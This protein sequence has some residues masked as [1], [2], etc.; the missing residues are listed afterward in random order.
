MASAT[1]HA[2]MGHRRNSLAD[3][4]AG[5]PRSGSQRTI[6]DGHLARLRQLDAVLRLAVAHA[7][8]M[9][10]DE[11]DGVFRGIFISESE[12]DGLID[13]GNRPTLASHG[14]VSVALQDF[15]AASAIEGISD[16]WGFSDFDNGVLVLALA[17]ELDLR[18]ERIY[19]Y[20]QDD[21]T[22]RRPTV[23]LALS[24]LCTDWNARLAQ[25]R[26]F[27]PDAPLLRSGMLR[28]TA[29][30]AAVDPPL[31]TQ[32]LRLDDRVVRALVG[33]DGLDNRLAAF[34]QRVTAPTGSLD[35][36]NQA[37]IVQRLVQYATAAA[38]GADRPLRLLFSGPATSGKR[39]AAAGLAAGLG[40]VLLIADLVRHPEWR[41][42]PVGTATL[43]L[44]EAVLSGAMLYLDG[45]GQSAAED[46]AATSLLR[47]LA[48]HPG[49]A[50]VATDIVTAPNFADDHRVLR[51]PFSLP[52]C[53]TQRLLWQRLAKR[54]G[55]T[56][57]SD[58]LDTLANT[59]QLAPDQIAEVVNIAHQR[60]DWR[61]TQGD[62]IN[63]ADNAEEL[64]TAA[65]GQS[66]EELAALTSR[67][68]PT[69][70]WAD[71]VLPDDSLEQLQ[72][73]C[74]RA[75]FRRA[76]LE[77]GGF[78]RKLAAGKGIAALFAG[79]SGTGKTMAAHVIAN[80][81]G[82]DLFRVDLSRVVSKYIGETEKNLE[83]IFNAATRSNGVLL[84]DEADSLMGKRSQVHDAHDRYANLEIS[85]LL[86]KMEQHEGITI[87]TTNLKANID[88]AFKRRLTYTVQFPLPDEAARL[89]I[90]KRMW[91]AETVVDED[92]DFPTLAARF[93]LSGGN[94]SNIGLSAAYLAAARGRPVRMADIM[95]ATRRE[96]AKVGKILAPAELEDMVR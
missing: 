83:R 91:P 36:D 5:Q 62:E 10:G 92:V 84:F 12:I 44:R 58:T 23:D 3:T 32:C 4:P 11:Q 69:Y 2:G 88:D 71:I 46:P 79:P 56:L 50:I 70:C 54:V 74:I 76:V 60:L 57:D 33:D 53:E 42:E 40:Q 82:L 59:F 65:R 16:H 30:D 80:E 86:Q 45:L 35:L 14:D 94:I 78:G 55:I 51:V 29:A 72:E 61:G 49:I 64:L 18:Y 27:A 66:G 73:V 41:E 39:Q 52:D 22:K 7:R 8:L 81:L 19:A 47:T 48:N 13:C 20:L 68:S 15:F 1:L 43:L 26:R 63:E 90:W 67:I 28:L 25:R 96:Y 37:D 21:V 89:A 34:C 87:L 31:L 17:P 93:R 24:L 77:R 38:R 85:Y 95:Q 6:R 9:F 75:R